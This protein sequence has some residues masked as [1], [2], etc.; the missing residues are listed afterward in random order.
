MKEKKKV[1]RM[2]NQIKHEIKKN[3]KKQHGNKRTSSL[4]FLK[5]ERLRK[6]IVAL[7]EQLQLSGIKFENHS[8]L[9]G[10]GKFDAQIE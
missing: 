6:T 5:K 2:K 10:T 7:V 8:T 4:F 3:Q 9:I 1:K